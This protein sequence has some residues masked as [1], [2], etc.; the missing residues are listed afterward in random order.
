MGMPVIHRWRLLLKIEDFT[1]RLWGGQNDQLKGIYYSIIA[2]EICRERGSGM[3]VLQK[4][5]RCP[6]IAWSHTS[7]HDVLAHPEETRPDGVGVAQ[8]TPLAARGGLEATEVNARR[9]GKR[10]PEVASTGG[11]VA[12]R[13]L[14][15]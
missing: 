15:A 10:P 9:V 12:L 7:R 1:A 2:Q 4:T 14:K 6:T 3:A 5:S 11:F 13:K 8:N